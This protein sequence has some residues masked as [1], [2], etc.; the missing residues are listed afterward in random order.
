MFRQVRTDTSYPK[1]TALDQRQFSA[2]CITNTTWKRRLR[3]G[4]LNFCAPKGLR[5]YFMRTAV[6]PPMVNPVMAP[7]V[8]RWKFSSPSI[9]E[10]KENLVSLNGMRDSAVPAL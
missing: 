1:A 6:C 8:P 4:R 3:D 9:T 10:E 2:A 5:G 7:S